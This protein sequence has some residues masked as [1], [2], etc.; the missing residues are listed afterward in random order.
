M[1][2]LIKLGLWFFSLRYANFCVCDK[3]VLKLGLALG[4]VFPILKAIE[5]ALVQGSFSFVE[6][7]LGIVLYPVFT[8]AGLM[9]FSKLDG[10]LVPL[11]IST[12]CSLFVIAGPD[13]IASMILAI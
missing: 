6:L 10:I 2:F 11:L 13:N 8:I 1:A 7:I 5:I 12:L 3:T 9:A 4:F